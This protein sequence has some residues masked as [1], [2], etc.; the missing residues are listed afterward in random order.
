[1]W[2]T[3]SEGMSIRAVWICISID[4]GTGVICGSEHGKALLLVIVLHGDVWVTPQDCCE[5]SID[6]SRGRCLW[7]V[8]W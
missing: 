6:A 3:S 1:M 4:G 2:S 8:V 5:R 7:G